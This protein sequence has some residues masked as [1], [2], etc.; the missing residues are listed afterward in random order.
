M[1]EP[2]TATRRPPAPNP[3]ERAKTIATRDCPAT[4]VP[5]VD[6]GEHDGSRV[7]PVLHHVH[8]SGGV[9]LLLPDGH[10]LVEAAAET[11][12]GEF[13]VMLELADHAPVPLRE[14]IRGLLWIT[15]WLRPLDPPAARARAAAIAV[16]RPDHRLLDVNHGLTMLRLTP[17]SLVLADADGTHSLRPHMFS[18]ATPDPFHDYEARWL[19]HL[20][21]EHA[22]VVEQLGRHLPQELRGGLIRPLGLDRHGLRLRVESAAGDHDVRLAFSQPVDSPPQLAVEIRRL[23]GC[24]FFTEG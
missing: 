1:T 2:T 15:G 21:T 18:A 22:D 17:A 12:R 16:D 19:Q 4:L 23:V 24:P 13:G 7:V 9:S 14:P 8:A 20:E 3:A 5:S 6:R 10:P 11:Q